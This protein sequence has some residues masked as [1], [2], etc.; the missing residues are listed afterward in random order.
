MN[1][2]ISEL[3]ANYNREKIIKH[4]KSLNEDPEK[5]N[6]SQ[7][8]KNM[9]KIWPKIGNNLPSAKRNH[10]GKIITDPNSF[11]LLLAKEYR[12][13]LRSRPIR[14]DLKQQEVLKTPN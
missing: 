8:W 7:M 10:Q 12:E 13:R 14:P 1:R 9:R 2:E 5:V 11:K 4:F 3:E 6:L